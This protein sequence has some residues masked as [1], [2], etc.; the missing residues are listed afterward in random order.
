MRRLGDGCVINGPTVAKNEVLIKPYRKEKATARLHLGGVKRPQL[1]EVEAGHSGVGSTGEAQQVVLPANQ[2][3]RRVICTDDGVMSRTLD[4]RS[5]MAQVAP[6]AVTADFLLDFCGAAI[7]VD[8]DDVNAAI[9]EVLDD[10]TPQLL[11]LVVAMRTECTKLIIRIRNV[12]TST[13]AAKLNAPRHL[14]IDRHATRD[15]II[16]HDDIRN[17]VFLV[18]L[19][20]ELDGLVHRTRKSVDEH[21]PTK[22]IAAAEDV[23]K[24]RDDLVV[25]GVPAIR[26]SA[27]VPAHLQVHHVFE[28]AF[29]ARS[30]GC[31]AAPSRRE[32]DRNAVAFRNGTGR[33]DLPVLIFTD[34]GNGRRQR[35]LLGVLPLVDSRCR[36]ECTG[37]SPCPPFFSSSSHFFELWCDIE[38]TNSKSGLSR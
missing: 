24:H 36:R 10:E 13:S 21:R 7:P 32:R 22:R 20:A 29:E 27:N 17:E 23:L 14:P 8:G 35:Q 2:T 1:V 18:H 9:A 25:R 12:S 6:V 11:M 26:L 37:V 5:T 38:R 33:D 31:F 30:K 4:E 34:R 16:E 3:K 28:P 19:V 15:V